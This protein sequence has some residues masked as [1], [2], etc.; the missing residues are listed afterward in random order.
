VEEA[1]DLL[2]TL[3]G[4]LGDASAAARHEAHAPPPPAGGEETAGQVEGDATNQDGAEE[5][6]EGN[7]KP[8]REK[9]YRLFEWAMGQNPSLK[10]DREV[11]DWLSS[12][13]ELPDELPSFDSWSKYLRD[14]RDYYD[15]H[16]HTPKT[17]K[18]AGGKSVVRRDQI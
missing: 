14:A 16:K 11:Y 4:A 10:T 1:A 17:T 6:G 3:D 9:A 7:L 8:S 15:D 5:Q 12:R 13:S 18:T 2:A